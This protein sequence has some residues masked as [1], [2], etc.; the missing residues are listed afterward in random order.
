MS[1]TS[2]RTDDILLIECHSMQSWA[3]T[4]RHG[5]TGKRRKKKMKKMFKQRAMKKSSLSS[6]F[7]D[8]LIELVK[9]I[10]QSQKWI[11]V[12]TQRYQTS[13]FII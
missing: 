1:T 11:T 10:P 7:E 2:K 9:E 13:K 12:Y 8:D 6:L 3:A 4:T 5:L